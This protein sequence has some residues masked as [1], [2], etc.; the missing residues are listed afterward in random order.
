MRTVEVVCVRRPILILGNDGNDIA[1][2]T[3][4]RYSSQPASCSGTRRDDILVLP[5]L[6]LLGPYVAS[7]SRMADE[8]LD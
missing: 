3:R 7:T 4:Q 2:C 8:I 6:V 1:Y 5:S